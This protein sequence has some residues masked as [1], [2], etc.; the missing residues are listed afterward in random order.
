MRE[1]E[2]KFASR[3]NSVPQNSNIDYSRSAAPITDNL[4]SQTPNSSQMIPE[5]SHARKGGRNTSTIKDELPSFSKIN[6]SGIVDEYAS[7]SRQSPKMVSQ[8]PK[9]SDNLSKYEER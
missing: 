2:N 6:S 1:P 9:K 4:P 3:N 8:T 5:E 7:N